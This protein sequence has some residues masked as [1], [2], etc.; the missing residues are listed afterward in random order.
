VPS[1]HTHIT[2][3]A[4]LPLINYARVHGKTLPSPIPASPFPPSPLAILWSQGTTDEGELERGS[5]G[6]AVL[7]LFSAETHRDAVLHCLHALVV[8]L[9]AV[10]PFARVVRVLIQGDASGQAALSLARNRPGETE[11]LARLLVEMCAGSTAGSWRRRRCVTLLEGVCS[12]APHLAALVRDALVRHRQLPALVVQLGFDMLH[13]FVEFVMGLVYDKDEL[14][15]FIDALN[16]PSVA[17]E[18]VAPIR[19]LLVELTNIRHRPGLEHQRLCGML[20]TACVLLRPGA[21]VKS[22]SAN[23]TGVVAK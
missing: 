15:W 20:R 23:D 4:S 6:P 2:T 22:F 12:L 11:R 9:P 14:G 10:L 19:S 17:A 3:L 18:C 5:D 16:T 8:R 1:T 7:P 21:V 13:D